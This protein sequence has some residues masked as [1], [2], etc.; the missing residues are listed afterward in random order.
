M[1]SRTRIDLPA[2]VTRPFEVYVNGVA[3]VEGTDFE[4]VGSSL[5]FSRSLER[6]APLGFWRW[7]RMA[8][9]VAGTYRRNDTIDVVYSRDGR[10][11]VASL[12]APA[13]APPGDSAS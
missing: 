8:L 7:M 5:V 2:H 10:R 4:T 13:A 9:G 11:L 3:Q 1:E 12:A 6:E